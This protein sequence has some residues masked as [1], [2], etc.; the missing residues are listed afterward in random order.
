MSAERRRQ[1]GQRALRLVSDNGL[2]GRGSL[3]NGSGDQGFVDSGLPSPGAPA[4]PGPLA[5]ALA[6]SPAASPALR[7]LQRE[8][9]A[10]RAEARSLQELLEELPAILE[11]K[12]ELRLQAV[13]TE[14]RQLEAGNALLQHHLLAL[15]GAGSLQRPAL[16]PAPEQEAAGEVGAGEVGEDPLDQPESPITQGL[17]LR[18]A[19]RLRH[20]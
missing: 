19:L 6:P 3:D 5:G 1:P 2:L 17:G 18:R 10:A 9:E 11:R 14:Q 16:P 13:L 7:R 4:G 8:L 15:G 12:F 20:R